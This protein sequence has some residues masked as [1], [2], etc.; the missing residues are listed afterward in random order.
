MKSG[1]PAIKRQARVP[2]I[3]TKRKKGGSAFYKL[4]RQ[5][6]EISVNVAFS[7]RNLTGVTGMV[8]GGILCFLNRIS[9]PYNENDKRSTIRK[10]LMA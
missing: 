9:E 6:K 8:I 4:N 5:G 3:L 2:H 1:L 10:K 7:F